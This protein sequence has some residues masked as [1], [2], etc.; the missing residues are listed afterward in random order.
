[1]NI[2][3]Y[4]FFEILQICNE[5]YRK[6]FLSRILLNVYCNK[7]ENDDLELLFHESFE[8]YE[9][10]T[11]FLVILNN[12]KLKIICIFFFIIEVNIYIY[13]KS[14]FTYYFY[15]LLNLLI[16]RFFMI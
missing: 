10:P 9:N 12:V 8:N 16:L 5:T 2:S 13:T 6:E 1:M 4:D 3:R 15:R 11:I 14:F 7:T